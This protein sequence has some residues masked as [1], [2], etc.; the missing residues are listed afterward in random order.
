M[1]IDDVY[2]SR[3]ELLLRDRERDMA[4]A[5]AEWDA[6]RLAESVESVEAHWVGVFRGMPE[7]VRRQ[8]W[9]GT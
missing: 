4:D 3:R 2:L 6:Q 5:K 8:H 9:D 7:W 1:T